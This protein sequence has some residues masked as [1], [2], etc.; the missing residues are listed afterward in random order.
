MRKIALA[1]ILLIAAVFTA[2]AQPMVTRTNALTWDN[3]NPWPLTANFTMTAYTQGG[4]Q[5]GTGTVVTNK[6]PFIVMM[7]NAA[8][9]SYFI[10]GITTDTN[11]ISS[12]P[13]TNFV[14]QWFGTIAIT[15]QPVSLT[16]KNAETA[17]FSVQT[18]G[19][20]GTVT[21]QWAR[22][23]SIVPGATSQTLI[24]T[25]AKPAD[26]GNY[27]VACTD[28]TGTVTSQGA[29]LFVIPKPLSPAGIRLAP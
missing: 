19:G 6:I 13:S 20:A 26:N 21:Y 17:T 23:G 12:D 4:A 1:A 22:N 27:T 7:G 28:T 5:I 15:T 8:N 10:N 11:G 24:I 3:P 18:F 9:G 29:T 25:N 16:V 2:S 14:F